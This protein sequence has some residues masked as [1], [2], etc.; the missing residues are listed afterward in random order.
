MW[1]QLSRW[2]FWPMLPITYIGRNLPWSPPYFVEVSPGV[3]LGGVPLVFAGHVEEL[4]RLGVRGVVN[5]QDE[6]VGPVK[7]YQ[8]LN[9]TQLYLPTV[10]HTEPSCAQMHTACTFIAKQTEAGH[11]VYVHCKGGHGR[12]AA[13]AFA[14][15]LKTHQK[16]LKETQLL[17]SGQRKV[18]KKLYTQANMVAFHRELVD[19]IE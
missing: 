2:Y 1:K 15:M 12:G 14:W 9:V 8:E 4:Y 3:I 10:D 17:L 13:I 6:Y 7:K 16:S 5:M 18:R 19:A 11:K